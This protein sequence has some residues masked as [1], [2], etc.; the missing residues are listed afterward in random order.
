MEQPRTISELR[1]EHADFESYVFRTTIFAK[2]NNEPQEEVLLSY[3]P[4]E[5]QFT[6]FELIGK[7]REQ[8]MNLFKQKDLN[9]LKS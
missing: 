1:W 4:D 3:F 2:F 8:A 9:Y 6:R 7:T 5:V